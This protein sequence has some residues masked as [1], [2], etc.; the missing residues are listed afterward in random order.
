M[1]GFSGLNAICAYARH[2]YHDVRL[3]VRFLN[4]KHEEKP[5]AKFSTTSRIDR[6][7]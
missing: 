5:Y 3:P 1:S 7:Q 6:Q 4:I 2:R